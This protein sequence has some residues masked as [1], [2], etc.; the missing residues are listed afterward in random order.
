MDD[1]DIRF[2]ND[3]AKEEQDQWISELAPVPVI[4]LKT[5]ITYAAYQHHP[6]TYLY[7]ENDQAVQ[8]EVQKIM[9][10]GAGIEIDTETCTAGHSPYL[11]QQQLMLDMVNKFVEV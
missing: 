8:W 4:A 11:S 9:V 3:L 6:T 2:Y 5:A 10:A 7:C 1:P